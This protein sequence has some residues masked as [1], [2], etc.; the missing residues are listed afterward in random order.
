M[1]LQRE[2]EEKKLHGVTEVDADGQKKVVLTEFVSTAVTL[3]ERSFKVVRE[4][5][6]LYRESPAERASL[7]KRAGFVILY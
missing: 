1:I 7:F 6:Q 4:Q 5:M 3:D 2:N